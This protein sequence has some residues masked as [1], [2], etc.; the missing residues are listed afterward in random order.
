MFGLPR[1]RQRR[2]SSLS[3]YSV[4]GITHRLN[5][6]ACATH[7]KGMHLS[8]DGKHHC[9]HGTL[10]TNPAFS[11]PPEYFVVAAPQGKLVV[12]K[13]IGDLRLVEDWHGKGLT[14]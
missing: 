11:L 2:R 9:W 13:V 6:Q 8:G 10:I 3:I 14:Q 1:H 4:A 5:L 12:P 7:P